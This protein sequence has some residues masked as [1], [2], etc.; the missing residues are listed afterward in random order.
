MMVEW[1]ALLIEETREEKGSIESIYVAK[2]ITS[3]EVCRMTL[4]ASSVRVPMNAPTVIDEG[5][6]IR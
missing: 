2:L 3:I 4:M 5:G 6:L 1:C